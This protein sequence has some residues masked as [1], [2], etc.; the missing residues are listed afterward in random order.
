MY[1]IIISMIFVC[2]G[3]LGFLYGLTQKTSCSVLEEKFLAEVGIA[4]QLEETTKAQNEFISH[5][6]EER[7]QLEKQLQKA[8]N[9]QDKA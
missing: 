7:D 2:A 5:L 3:C 4:T 1:L 6:I 8:L 9:E